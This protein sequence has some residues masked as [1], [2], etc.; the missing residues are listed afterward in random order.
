ML[1]LFCLPLAGTSSILRFYLPNKQKFLRLVT[2]LNGSVSLWPKTG[3]FDR[4][5]HTVDWLHKELLGRMWRGNKKS[6][7]SLRY[8][9]RETPTSTE[10]R[11]Q[12]L[13]TGKVSSARLINGRRQ[14]VEARLCTNNTQTDIFITGRHV[15][16]NRFQPVS[17]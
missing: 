14:G 10:I 1:I 11:N 13:L 15:V 7:W 16:S 8:F 12:P 4:G 17:W 5:F 3:G 9:R 6:I 2:L